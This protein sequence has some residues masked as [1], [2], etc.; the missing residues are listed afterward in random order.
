MCL[1]LHLI[2]SLLLHLAVFLAALIGNVVVT[3]IIRIPKQTI[4]GVPWV[5]LKDRTIFLKLRACIG[6]LGAGRAVI[7]E[8]WHNLSW[9][10]YLSSTFSDHDQYGKRG[11]PFM[12]PGLEWSTVVLPPHL[13]DWMMR[14]P[15]SVLSGVTPMS[16]AIGAK[17]LGHGPEEASVLDFTALRRDLTP[18]TAKLVRQIQ[19][20]IDVAFDAYLNANTDGQSK[21]VKIKPMIESVV[22]YTTNRIFVGLPLCRSERF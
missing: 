2:L 18:H 17:Y 13:A 21:E 12:L 1:I 10:F 3:R 7:E 14:Q 4:P 22:F 11:R 5:G 15:D 20:E 8:G 9:A 19:D 6:E 16:D